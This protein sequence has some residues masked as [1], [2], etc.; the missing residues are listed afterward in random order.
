MKATNAAGTSPASAKSAAVTPKAPP[1]P[2]TVL[3]HGGA[4]RYDTAVAVSKAMFPTAGVPVAYVASGE[5]FADALAGAAA[6]GKLGGPVL[7]T[8]PNALPSVVAAELDRLNPQRIVI[9]GG[10]GVVSSAVAS[11]VKAYSPSVVRQGGAKRYDTAVAVSK[12]TY[13]T[14]GV[15]VVYIANGEDFPDAL[16]GAAA[17][18][19]L[20][21]PVLLTPAGGLPSVVSTELDRLNPQRI[22]ILGGTGVVSTTVEKQVA[23]YVGG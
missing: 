23:Q 11:K 13:P 14:P 17:A 3:R 8:Q 21:G 10:T 2:G 18:G 12:A 5:G 16:A 1:A 4:S 9:L 6:A 7:L 15:P 22:V 19:K 20:G